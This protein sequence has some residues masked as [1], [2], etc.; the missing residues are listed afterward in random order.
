MGR[1]RYVI[2]KMLMHKIESEE[3]VMQLRK[4]GIQMG[5][6]GYLILKIQ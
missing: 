5:G 2:K 3:Y 6:V 1:L 4:R